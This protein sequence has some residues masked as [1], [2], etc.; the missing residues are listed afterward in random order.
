MEHTFYF[1][2][3]VAD[4]RAWAQTYQE[5]IAT[6]GAG[7]GMSPAEITAEQGYC[8]DIMDVIDE[9]DLAAAEAKSKNQK[10]D[11]VIKE[12]MD[13]LRPNI[14]IH[15]KNTH[16][17]E[18][19]GKLLGIVGSEIAIDYDAIKPVAKLKMIA[20]GVSIKFGM[21]HCEAAKI[22]CRRGKDTDFTLLMV[23]TH[24]HAIDTRPNIDDQPAEFRQY[25]IVMLN[26]DREVGQP[27]D[28]AEITVPQLILS[29]IHI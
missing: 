12:K 13:K 1:P 26:K 3:T 4:Q 15:K 24:A 23:V 21:L 6:E 10:K 5:N 20:E 25:R 19:I 7:L 16:Y 29:L 2:P 8:Q 28:P 14:T 9:S 27:S 11:E 17:T 22:F 18:S